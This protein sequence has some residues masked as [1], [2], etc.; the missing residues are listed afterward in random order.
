MQA[1][2]T[3]KEASVQDSDKVLKDLEK[4]LADAKVAAETAEKELAEL[5]GKGTLTSDTETLRK[6]HEATQL[7]VEKAR[8]ELVKELEVANKEKAEALAEVEKI[9]KSRRR[10]T[11]V[12]RAGVLKHLSGAPADDFGEFL[13][14]VEKALGD[15]RFTKFLNQLD[16][17]NTQL[18]KNA[19]FTE[20][21]RSGD[22]SFSLSG[23][24]A[25]LDIMAKEIVAK[26]DGK[27]TYAKAYDR[28]LTSPEG[29]AIYKRL[30]ASEE[31]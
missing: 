27:V 30:R 17:W 14:D 2:K 7:A 3:T 26:S 13:D 10:E 28:V 16:A 5:K 9:R 8:H 31:R 29:R 21:G 23:P 20:M 15:K 6:Q 25:Q 4:Q 12:K 22:G 19:I 1:K 18:E 11:F 24:E